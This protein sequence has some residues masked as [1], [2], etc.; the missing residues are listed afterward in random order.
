MVIKWQGRWCGEWKNIGL[1]VKLHI[2][3]LMFT[4]CAVLATQPLWISPSSS[5]HQSPRQPRG[6]FQVL[7]SETVHAS[8][9]HACVFL[10][11]SNSQPLLTLLPVSC[12]PDTTLL[13]WPQATSPGPWERSYMTGSIPLS[14]AWEG[15]H[16]KETGCKMVQI[17]RLFRL[18]Y[19]FIAAPRDTEG[20]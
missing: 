17:C 18:L 4:S 19:L 16:W 5:L 1:R 11:L 9:S 8:L 10:S 6:P 12:R 20:L 14:G 15:G 2:P 13:G 3:T 7:P